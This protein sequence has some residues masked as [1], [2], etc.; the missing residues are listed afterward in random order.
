MRITNRL[1]TLGI[2]VVV[3]ALCCVPG[4]PPPTAAYCTG[5]FEIPASSYTWQT[6]TDV[7]GGGGTITAVA[8]H[9]PQ[10]GKPFIDV[11]CDDYD[12]HGI[13]WVQGIDAD[14]NGVCY[15]ETTGR[16]SST[17]CPASLAAYIFYIDV[18]PPQ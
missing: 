3:G 7:N 12:C 15:V 4:R 16:E 17:V 10:D 11:S 14:W 13:A 5:T 18:A 2:A 9:R 1:P 6:C 8:G